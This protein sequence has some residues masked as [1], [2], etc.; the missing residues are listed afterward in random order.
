MTVQQLEQR[1]AEANRA[2]LALM[3]RIETQAREEGRQLTENEKLQINRANLE[4]RDLENR[5]RAARSDAGMMRVLE[6]RIGA[7]GAGRSRIETSG[8]PTHARIGIQAAEEIGRWYRENRSKLPSQNAWTS[9]GF[10]LQA[11][12]LDES[13]GSGGKLLVPDYRPGIV[14]LPT[15]RLVVADLPADGAT[16]GSSVIYMKETTFT[17]AAAPTAEGAAKPESTLVFDNVTDAVRKIAHWLPVTEEMLE[18]VSA[19]RGYLDARLRTGVQLAEDDQLLNGSGIAPN[20]QGFLNRVGLAAA[21]ARG[22]DNNADA[23]AKQIAA[24]ETATNMPVDGI[25]INPTNWLTITL[26]KDANGQYYGAGPF[27]AGLAKALWGRR[28]AITSAIAAGTALVGAFGTG[29]QIFRKGGLRVEASNAH[30]D[31]FVKNLVAIRA[32]ERLALAVYRPSA[33]GTV[34]GLN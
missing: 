7:G 1:A 8:A 13:A 26:A 21:V 31:Y 2:S 17:N 27:A 16:D 19:L 30:N 9:P 11:T 25:V 33:F 4:V 24:I 18:D 22:A 20:L 14:E 29:S 12:T 10:E 32:E 3:N 6:E 28:V 5:V 15:R 23:I 34:T